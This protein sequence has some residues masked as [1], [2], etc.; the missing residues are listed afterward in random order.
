MDKRCEL[1]VYGLLIQL[2]V[3]KTKSPK[4]ILIPS[5]TG[6]PLWKHVGTAHF[7]IEPTD[8][9]YPFSFSV[10]WKELLL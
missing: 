6:L 1:K 10:N 4:Q 5:I 2:P 3:L 9:K 8:L 7:F